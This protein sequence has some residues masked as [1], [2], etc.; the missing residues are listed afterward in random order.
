M[1]SQKLPGFTAEASLARSGRY[2]AAA[3]GWTLANRMSPGE[4]IPQFGG[5]H[6]HCSEV[7]QCVRY[8]C[9]D[10]GCAYIDIC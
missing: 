7:S 5:T 1:T 4:I 2:H 6:S 10:W 9:G 8:C 3:A